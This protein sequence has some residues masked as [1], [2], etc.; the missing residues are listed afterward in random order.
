M[1][2]G[3]GDNW[4][5]I[6]NVGLSFV[7]GLAV[8][9]IAWRQWQTAR[10]KLRFDLFDR[11]YALYES[12]QQMIN[13]ALSDTDFQLAKLGSYL[14][15]NARAQFLLNDDAVDKYISTL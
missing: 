8:A 10:Q 4:V 12:L 5:A 7:I 9:Y 14:T 2:A 15:A 11:R 3:C 1:G 13:A 6:S